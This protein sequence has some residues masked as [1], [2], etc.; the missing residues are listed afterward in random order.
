M[1]DHDSQSL[2]LQL[3]APQLGLFS[4]MA[5]D[6]SFPNR[7]TSIWAPKCS[8]VLSIGAPCQGTPNLGNPAMQQVFG[9]SC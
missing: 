4:Y 9:T 1:Q 7:V 6:G 5:L 3:S 8:T 2:A